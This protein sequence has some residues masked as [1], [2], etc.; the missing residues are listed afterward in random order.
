M[1]PTVVGIR[2]DLICGATEAHQPAYYGHRGYYGERSFRFGFRFCTSTSADYLLIWILV[3]EAARHC[4]LRGRGRG[5]APCFASSVHPIHPAFDLSS[6]VLSVRVSFCQE[7]ESQEGQ[8]VQDGGYRALAGRRRI[9][10][11]RTW[12]AVTELVDSK[13]TGGLG[14]EESLRRCVLVRECS[15]T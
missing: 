8:E 4:L 10:R 12:G 6:Y 5:R 14:T 15:D 1:H 11:G 2:R 3:G 7:E 13:Q 9:R